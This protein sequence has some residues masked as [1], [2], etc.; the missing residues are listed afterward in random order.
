MAKDTQSQ[1]DDQM[2]EFRDLHARHAAL[3]NGLQAE[4]RR[5]DHPDTL[6]DCAGL[7]RLF[8]GVRPTDQ[9]LRQAFLLPWCKEV[10]SAQPLAQRCAE[11]IHER[12]IIQMARDTAPQDLIAF[13][14]LLIHLHS[15]APVG[16]LEV[17]RLAQFWSD[18]C[19][20]RFVE[21]FYL[22]LYSLDQGDAA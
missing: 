2:Q 15:Q 12:R 16:W 13:R 10:E 3:P 9:Q 22:N 1:D 21:D 4:L 20:R 18:R 14:R 11:H 8:P 6:R 17:A 19:K 7:Y 5:V